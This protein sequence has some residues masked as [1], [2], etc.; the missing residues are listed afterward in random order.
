MDIRELLTLEANTTSIKKI[1]Q[2]LSNK[3]L[4]DRDYPKAISHL[5]YL[6]FLLGDVSSSFQ[7]LFNYLEKCIDKEKPTVYN[8]LIKIYY[9]F[10]FSPAF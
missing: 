3:S 5:A 1:D 6:T 8:T 4:N 10:D 2:F 9:F 7:L